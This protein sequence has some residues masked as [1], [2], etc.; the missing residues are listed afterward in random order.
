MRRLPSV[1]TLEDAFP[2]K[3]KALREALLMSKAQLSVLP[4]YGLVQLF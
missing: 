3:G 4:T 1:K 2:G